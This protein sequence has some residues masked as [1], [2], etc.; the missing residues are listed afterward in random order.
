MIAIA[1]PAITVATIITISVHFAVDKLGEID[2]EV[3]VLASSKPE[4]EKALE[5]DRFYGRLHGCAKD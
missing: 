2:D 5:I 4:V 1:A 3:L